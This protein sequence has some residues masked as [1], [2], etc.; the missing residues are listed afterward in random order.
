VDI[1]APGQILGGKYRL[2][3]RIGSGG[4]ASIWSAT[5]VTLNRLVAVKFVD[6]RTTF[7]HE[8]RVGKFLREAKVAASIR[9]K[10]VVDILDFGVFDQ[11][12]DSAQ[13]GMSE[14]YM[15]MELL[16]GEAL[17]AMLQRAPL[18][19]PDTLSLIRQTLS[20]LDAVHAAGI[21]HRDMKPG[22]VFV[23]VDEDG[24]FA[25]VLDFG[26]SQG[27]EDVADQAVV[28][29]PEYMSPEQAYG[30][31]LDKRTDIY[32]VGVM[33]Y[34][35][36]SGVLPFDD[37]D[38]TR[39]L[40]LVVDGF[41]P[42]LSKLRGDI[43]ELCA[44]VETAMAR[45]R[46]DRFQ[47]A[48]E[49]QRAI[50]EATGTPDGTGRFSVPPRAMRGSGQYRR[51]AK[52]LEAPDSIPSEAGE[53]LASAVPFVPLGVIQTHTTGSLQAPARRRSVVWITAS[54][55]LALTVIAIALAIRGG[56]PAETHAAVPPVGAAP[57]GAAPV[58]AA[59][60]GAAPIGAAPVAVGTAPTPAAPPEATVVPAPAAPPETTVE[61]QA[62]E[63]APAPPTSVTRPT[64]DRTRRRSAPTRESGSLAR[65]LDF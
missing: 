13:P 47:T 4:M 40:R 37:P 28:G 61:A 21:V 59:P 53:D 57:V 32:S 49:M 52:T 62:P 36:L 39:V 33:M 20:G 45:R 1:G 19:T 56:A 35:M 44:V 46:E 34:E 55:V 43:P 48:R 2:E 14:P 60:V 10:N 25:R 64:S 17:D 7:G 31:Q 8:E 27:A 42:P 65:E 11:S 3:R 5:H 30:E 16:E 18:S 26:I 54:V 51:E 24:Y 58:G 41:V 9:H 29:T 63:A 15:I 23:T 38:P 50:A 22:N 12:P 6:A